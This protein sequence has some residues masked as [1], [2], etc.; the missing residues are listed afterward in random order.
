MTE[1]DNKQPAKSLFEDYQ[2]IVY[3]I[4]V[5]P[6][7]EMLDSAFDVLL[8]NNVA[9]PEMCLGFHH[10]MHRAKDKMEITENFANRKKV[11]LVTSLFEKSID[12]K[13][14][15]DDGEPYI[16]I[17]MGLKEL[18]KD[19]DPESPQILSRAFLKLWEMIVYFDLI[20]NNE[21]F[22]SA[23]LAEGPG[24]F[25]QATILFRDMLAKLKK[26]KSSKNDKYFAV[27]LHSDN[28]HLLMEKEFINYY[29]KEKPKRLHILETVNKRET[30]EQKGGGRIGKATDGDITNLHTINLFGGSQKGGDGYAEESDLVTADGGFDW[31][32]E[33]LQ[34]QEAYR[35][36][37]GQMLAA[38]KTQK[39]G[40]NFV[41]KIFETYTKNTIK[42]LEILRLFYSEV[43]ICKPF[44]SRISNS[45]KYVVCKN[46][47]KK[48]FNSSISKKMEEMVS[49]M[50]K[51][52]DFNVIE[53]FSTFKLS[54]KIMELYKNINIELSL[55]QYVGINNIIQFIH[56]DNYNG[57]EYNKYLDKQIQASRF[58]VDTFLN[59]S[60]F[61]L[62]EK[63]IDEHKTKFDKVKPI[64]TEVKEKQDEKELSRFFNTEPSKQSRSKGILTKTKTKSKTIKSTKAKKTQKGGGNE[65]DPEEIIDSEPTDDAVNKFLSEPN[66]DLSSVDSNDE[67]M[68]K[69][70]NQID[71]NSDVEEF[72][73]PVLKKGEREI[74]DIVEDKLYE[75]EEIKMNRSKVNVVSKKQTKTK[76]NSKTKTKTKTKKTK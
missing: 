15:T 29:A 19:I 67:Y 35:L 23:H 32:K 53:L 27:T 20:P 1:K 21:K 39:S 75:M 3:K 16:S 11:Y 60:K 9:Y 6:S 70:K 52:Q 51:N 22:V 38:L 46:F 57:N 37:F 41:L 8:S 68:T 4:D 7:T 31:K 72:T 44:T 56:L 49:V 59:Y 17:D 55:K 48:L 24:S 2:P 58:W 76:T 33:N 73:E 45:E 25:I 18:I 47:N 34:E 61:N 71:F 74:M 5:T 36:I 26:I 10:F 54:N 40:G 63:W 30:K 13:E 62:I 66:S 50:N 43:Y 65:S 14:K 28:E 64:T 12:K 69:L 42:I